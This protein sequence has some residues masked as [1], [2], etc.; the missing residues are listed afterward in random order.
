M[1]CGIFHGIK[2][3]EKIRLE[4]EMEVHIIDRN[5]GERLQEGMVVVLS[6]FKFTSD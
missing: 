3:G 1:V 2:K 6:S 5:D 4:G